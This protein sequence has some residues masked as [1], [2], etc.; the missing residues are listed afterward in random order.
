M[1]YTANVALC[2]EIRKKYTAQ[3]E[4]HIEYLNVKPSGT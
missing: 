2:S 1:T 4:H 3:G